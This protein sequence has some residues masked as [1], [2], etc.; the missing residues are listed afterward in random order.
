MQDIGL[1]K[2]HDPKKERKTNTD[3]K[4]T[5][6]SKTLSRIMKIILERNSIGRTALSLKA[7]INYALLSRH[8]AWME[9]KSLIKLTV[10]NGKVTVKLTSH[11]REFATEF[12]NL[13]D[14]RNDQFD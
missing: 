10:E 14:V 4:F 9:N 3:N 11:G 12:C 6:S 8:L 13:L 5:P 2:G 1:E 7:N